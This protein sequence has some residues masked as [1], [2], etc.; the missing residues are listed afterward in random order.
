MPC[1]GVEWLFNKFFRSSGE[2]AFL[3]FEVLKS[4]AKGANVSERLVRLS[5]AAALN[6]IFEFNEFDNM[7]TTLFGPAHKR[8]HKTFGAPA[9][10]VE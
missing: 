10:P 6:S 3:S 4:D 2:K 8:L 7:V 9:T 1:D 5:D